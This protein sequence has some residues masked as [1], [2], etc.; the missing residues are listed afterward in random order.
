MPS[1]AK[2]Y[3]RQLGIIKKCSL[4]GRSNLRV[5]SRQKFSYFVVI[6]FESTCWKEEKSIVQEIIEFPA[7]LINSS[8]GKVESEFHYYVQP[9]EHPILSDFCKELTGITQAQVERGIPLRLCL[10][11]FCKWMRKMSEEKGFV[12]DNRLGKKACAFI[13]WSDWDLSV[14]LHNECK[15]KQIR[16]PIELNSWIDLRRVFKRFYGK[17]PAG[18]EGGLKYV[19]LEFQGRQHSGLEDSRNT[20][21]LAY[22]LICDGCVL[23][24][25]RDSKDICATTLTTRIIHS[26]DVSI[27]NNDDNNKNNI[28]SLREKETNNTRSTYQCINRKFTAVDKIS[29]P[30]IK[31]DNNKLFA[32]S[33]N[34]QRKMKK[35]ILLNPFQIKDNSREISKENKEESEKTEK[36]TNNHDNGNEKLITKS[37]IIIKT[38][39]FSRPQY[40]IIQEKIPIKDASK[41]QLSEC[42]WA[43]SK[44]RKINDQLKEKEQLGKASTPQR[45]NGTSNQSNEFKTPNSIVLNTSKNKSKMLKTPPMCQCGRR[46]KRK[47]V[48]TPGPNMGRNFYTCSYGR[49][50]SGSGEGC[51]FF[52]W[53]GEDKS[54]TN[55][56]S[57][58]TYSYSIREEYMSPEMK[59]AK[60]N[61]SSE[62]VDTNRKEKIIEKNQENVFKPVLVYSA[63]NQLKNPPPTPSCDGDVCTCSQADYDPIDNKCLKGVELGQSCNEDN[64]YCLD[65]NSHCLTTCQCKAG[66]ENVGEVCQIR[67]HTGSD[68]AQQFSGG[69]QPTTERNTIFLLENSVIK[70]SGTL[71]QYQYKPSS[72]GS[73]TIQIWR[74]MKVIAESNFYYKLIHE[75]E[76]VVSNQQLNSISSFTLAT[77]IRVEANDIIGYKTV[78]SANIG[79]VLSY[80]STACQSDTER[81]QLLANYQSLSPNSVLK[82][83]KRQDSSDCQIRKYPINA[84][85]RPDDPIHRGCVKS[86]TSDEDMSI[87]VQSSKLSVDQC[88]HYCWNLGYLYSELKYPNMCRC[89]PFF[90][91][92]D[93]D[94]VFAANI[95]CSSS[96]TRIGSNS[97][98]KCGASSYASV[99]QFP[100]TFINQKID[101]LFNSATEFYYGINATIKQPQGSEICKEVGGTLVGDPTFLNQ[102]GGSNIYVTG[103]M[104]IY[105]LPSANGQESIQLLM[106]E[107]G[108]VVNKDNIEFLPNRPDNVQGIENCLTF[109]GN[110]KYEDNRCDESSGRLLCIFDKYPFDNSFD[111]TQEITLS[112]DNEINTKW[113]QT[114]GVISYVEGVINKAIS[115]TNNAYIDILYNRLSCFDLP[116]QCQSGFSFMF[117][118]KLLSTKD[119]IIFGLSSDTG[120]MKTIKLLYISQQLK[121]SYP[122]VGN[123]ET[124]I[125]LI[126]S[127]DFTAWNHLAIIQSINGQTII[128]K[129]YV[130]GE[131]LQT[132]NIGLV[133]MTNFIGIRYGRSINDQNLQ[134]NSDIY[135]DELKISNRLLLDDNIYREYEKAA[136]KLNNEMTFK[137]SKELLELNNRNVEISLGIQDIGYK[138]NSI[139]SGLKAQ[140]ASV[141][142][143]LCTN[144]FTL[145]IWLRIRQPISNYNILKNEGNGFQL[146]YL[147]SSNKFQLKNK[148]G[149]FITNAEFSLP[150]D[151]WFHLAWKSHRQFGT[152]VFL[153]SKQIKNVQF[154]QD[155]SNTPSTSDTTNF[156]SL[157]IGEETS[158]RCQQGWEKYGEKCLYVSK[159]KFNYKR[160]EIFCKHK[161]SI[162]L[163][164]SSLEEHKFVKSLMI[165]KGISHI[166]FGLT[167]SGPDNNTWTYDGI[168]PNYI[169]PDR[170][171]SMDERYGKLSKSDTDL[172]DSDYKD[173]Y[174]IICEKP[175][176]IKPTNDRDEALPNWKHFN[177]FFYYISTFSSSRMEAIEKCNNYS[178]N[179]VSIL[180]EREYEYLNNQLKGKGSFFIG[181]DFNANANKYF[182]KDG[183]PVTAENIN[184]INLEGS[185]GPN[186]LLECNSGQNCSIVKSSLEQARFICKRK[187]R[188]LNRGGCN[189]GDYSFN[190]RCL[191]VIQE[192]GKY[193]DIV[194]KCNLLGG[195]AVS[196]TNQEDVPA[197]ES[198]MIALNQNGKSFYIGG[199]RT[200]S[201]GDYYWIT[202]E[203]VTSINLRD[204]GS[205]PSFCSI[206]KLSNDNTMYMES[207]CNN[208]DGLLCE[209]DAG[210]VMEMDDLRLYSS[211]L[212]DTDITNIYKEQNANLKILKIPC[213]TKLTDNTVRGQKISGSGKSYIDIAAT[214]KLIYDSSIMKDVL[215]IKDSEFIKYTID[216]NWNACLMSLSSCLGGFSIGFWVKFMGNK[217]LFQLLSIRNQLTISVETTLN[218]KYLNLVINELNINEKAFLPTVNDWFYLSIAYHLN[219]GLDVYANTHKILSSPT[220]VAS[221]GAFAPGAYLQIGGELPMRL[222]DFMFQTNF[223]NEKIIFDEVYSLKRLW[224]E[225]FNSQLAGSS[226]VLEEHN[227]IFGKSLRMSPSDQSYIITTDQY[228]NCLTN[229]DNCQNGIT[230]SFFMFWKEFT[231]TFLRFYINKGNNNFLLSIIGTGNNFKLTIPGR[232]ASINIPSSISKLKWYLYVFTIDFK[233]NTFLLYIDGIRYEMTSV[234]SDHSF[235]PTHFSQIQISPPEESL[236]IDELRIHN[237]IVG[238]WSYAIPFKS[239]YEYY[240]NGIL[241]NG[242]YYIDPDG[243]ESPSQ[244]V[245]VTCEMDNN[246]VQS[247]FAHDRNAKLFINPSVM[248]VDNEGNAKILLNYQLDTKVLREIIKSSVQ[249]YQQLTFECSGTQNPVRMMRQSI[250]ETTIDFWKSTP[251]ETSTI[252]CSTGQNFIQNTVLKAKDQLPITSV[253]IQGIESN[254]GEQIWSVGP[255]VCQG[256]DKRG[257]KFAFNKPDFSNIITEEGMQISSGQSDGLIQTYTSESINKDVLLVIGKEITIEGWISIGVL[258]KNVDTETAKVYLNGFELATTPSSISIDRSSNEKVVIGSASSIKNQIL[259]ESLI[260]YET[261]V[262]KSKYEEKFPRFQL[263]YNFFMDRVV[264]IRGQSN[265]IVPSKDNKDPYFTIITDNP[266]S[267]MAKLDNN[268][269]GIKL[270]DGA[271]T[272]YFYKECIVNLEACNRGFSLGFWFITNFRANRKITVLNFGSNFKISIIFETTTKIEVALTENDGSNIIKMAPISF[273]HWSH[274]GVVYD[275]SMNGAVRLYVNGENIVSSSTGRRKRSASSNSQQNIPS[276]VVIGSKESSTR[277]PFIIDDVIFKDDIVDFNEVYN[278]PGFQRSSSSS[279]SSTSGFIRRI[280]FNEFE[281]SSQ[282]IPLYPK[283]ASGSLPNGAVK[284]NDYISLNGENQYISTTTSWNSDCITN[285]ST[286]GNGFALAF[287]F[288]FDEITSQDQYFLTLGSSGINENGL[289]FGFLPTDDTLPFRRH[290]TI[291]YKDRYKKHSIWFDGEKDTWYNMF[292]SKSSSISSGLTVFLNDQKL[293]KNILTEN[294]QGSQTEIRSCI[295]GKHDK[296]NKNFAKI[297]IRTF[298]FWSHSADHPWDNNIWLSISLTKLTEYFAYFPMS[299]GKRC[300]DMCKNNDACLSFS[301]RGIH[302][303]LSTKTR[304]QLTALTSSQTN[305]NFVERLYHYL[306]DEKCQSKT[307]FVAKLYGSKCLQFS[308]STKSFT[309]AKSSCESLTGKPYKLFKIDDEQISWFNSNE[310]SSQSTFFTGYTLEDYDKLT[311]NNWAPKQPDYFRQNSANCVPIFGGKT[312]S[313]SMNDCNNNEKSYYICSTNLYPISYKGC[314]SESLFSNTVIASI[315]NVTVEKCAE[316]CKTLP[317]MRYALLKNGNIC[318]CLKFFD[319]TTIYNSRHCMIP[320]EG[321]IERYCGGQSSF[322]VY[323]IDYTTSIS[324]TGVDDFN[325]I[326]LPSTI[327]K[328]GQ[329]ISIEI[330]T[331]V[332]DKAGFYFSFSDGTKKPWSLVNKTEHEFTSPGVYYVDVSVKNELSYLNKTYTIIVQ[333]AIENLEIQSD[334]RIKFSQEYSIDLS[335]TKGTNVTCKITDEKEITINRFFPTHISQEK[336]VIPFS[337]VNN[338]TMNITC[339]NL[340]NAVSKE[341]SVIV[342]EEIRDLT[343]SV[344]PDKAPFGKTILIIWSIGKG[345][346]VSFVGLLDNKIVPID[347]VHGQ[348]SGSYKTSTTPIGNHTFMLQ[349][350]NLV[351]GPLNKTVKFQITNGISDMKLRVN[352][353]IIRTG[354]ETIATVFLSKG[355][356]FTTKIWYGDGTVETHQTNDEIQNFERVFKYKYKQPG[357]YLLVVQVTNGLNS[358]TENST[359]Y[360]LNTVK[361]ITVATQNVSASEEAVFFNFLSYKNNPK[362]T[363][364]TMTIDF[365]DGEKFKTIDVNNIIFPYYERYRYLREGFYRLQVNISNKLDDNTF[366]RDVQVGHQIKG[367]T[368]T[369]PKTTVATNVPLVLTAD[370]VKG[371]K[372]RYSFSFGDGE[373]YIDQKLRTAP[374]A[375]KFLSHSWKKEGSFD[376]LLNATNMFG[377]K[378]S[379]LT[380][381]VQEPILGL[382]LT[383]NGPQIPDKPVNFVLT[384]SEIGTNSCFKWE[385]GDGK[386]FLFGYPLCPDKNSNSNFLVIESSVLKISHNYTTSGLYKAT[387]T[388]WNSVSNTK[389]SS[390]VAIDKVLCNI[391]EV[392]LQNTGKIIKEANEVYRS[393]IVQ[394]SSTVQMQCNPPKKAVNTWS[395]YQVSFYFNG[396]EKL[397]RIQI[398]PQINQMSLK[399]PKRYLALGI[400]KVV[401]T[402]NPEG[403]KTISKEACGYFLIVSSPLLPNM[404]GGSRRTAPNN[405]DLSLDASK[406]YDPDVDNPAFSELSY[407]W[408]CRLEH[409]KF[410][411]DSNEKLI[412]TAT[413]AGSG[414]CFGDGPGKLTYSTAKAVVDNRLLKY[415]HIYVFKLVIYKDDRLAEYDQTVEIIGGQNQK[416]SIECKSNCMRKVDASQ[417]L[418]V[419]GKCDSCDM[420]KQHALTY[421]WSLYEQEDNTEKF[422]LVK[423][424]QDL[425][426]SGVTKRFLVLKENVLTFGKSYRLRFGNLEAYSEY[427]FSVNYPPYNGHCASN[428]PIGFALETYFIFK[429][430][431][432]LDE[433][434]RQ[435]RDPIMDAKQPVTLS[436]IFQYAVRGRDTTPILLFEYTGPKPET[437]KIQMPQ[438]EEMHD[439]LIDIFVTIRD[440]QNTAAQVQF[441]IQVLPSRRTA[442]EIQNSTA[443]EKLEADG[444]LVGVFRFYGQISELRT[445]I[446]R[447]CY[448]LSYPI[449]NI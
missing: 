230:I 13:T 114:G 197:L 198:I 190:G 209:Y 363:N 425:T 8:T 265:Y 18:L 277:M 55:L 124:T 65:I 300:Q 88:S 102:N 136:L 183:S 320:C 378:S 256:P 428:I 105:D 207:L 69:V 110:S 412:D 169:P 321:D 267:L 226:A 337:K 107:K 444:D 195:E 406:S 34:E 231:Q 328:T 330:N 153:N 86:R 234:F 340:L 129:V 71:L 416:L 260:L 3:A 331:D 262:E 25:T 294:L 414:G 137:V 108:N 415:G 290:F 410:A 94:S 339:S 54:A 67:L 349:A 147:V 310:D 274:I 417:S 361:F 161:E 441:K 435:K 436:Y 75:N 236:L 155:Q 27:D 355:S 268:I 115:I 266:M 362:P 352:S 11:L 225:N 96:C 324:V 142:N 395:L 80:I 449:K 100:S 423:E 384:I 58:S 387:V 381:I 241:T 264:E 237:N 448:M 196:L 216:S 189:F 151:S 338:Y 201:G 101:S 307:G 248:Q 141:C 204:E 19:G 293:T 344:K 243:I 68:L 92:K 140:I 374:F 442:K 278:S 145:S 72:E 187:E 163:R 396:T 2:D 222:R 424:F 81:G 128:W 261:F 202:G 165:L 7:V 220:P 287:E 377:Q 440:K 297:S 213:S 87:L 82:F 214:S 179:L 106:N 247:Q 150:F 439:N 393:E 312:A 28:I 336:I 4:K 353:Q 354:Y 121:L 74:L 359:I 175:L 401:V 38:R 303:Y 73:F 208:E 36:M 221:A 232:M 130:N 447:D 118:M 56:K 407:N 347:Y 323:Q 325:A 40:E 158:S 111:T 357:V 433:G 280:L 391:P 255:L 215:D 382:Q 132:V 240:E 405:R 99:Y 242:D 32:I 366:T 228:A 394:I 308:Q 203:I 298:T 358:F 246:R 380:I 60:M 126:S 244:P 186:I 299:G 227:L 12:F 316:E 26:P 285:P 152:Y 397:T 144:G 283:P 21:K 413:Q 157:V 275:K 419:I 398:P 319:I 176:S 39:K 95:R 29:S 259:I 212:P 164:I 392:D 184:Y 270:T 133:E 272:A 217:P 296:E 431:K 223:W 400:Y 148:I 364:A 329:I 154:V 170:N 367:L 79:N 317:E 9:Q 62:T 314:F 78:E 286:C 301:I 379:K 174:H 41:N 426:N 322:D 245:L 229:F 402:V 302:C 375:E 6:D 30:T 385:F 113:A 116:A 333:D 390:E 409:E 311:Y 306:P 112:F 64:L 346:L 372:C 24:L 1:T 23:T 279:T 292:I 91:T 43:L 368:L 178:S 257:I 351:S 445:K 10:D 348:L 35:K 341:I 365:G 93:D 205:S 171:P 182:W 289:V 304:T 399:L 125:S 90:G 373:S 238:D 313:W 386:E 281:E 269:N 22:K 376:I 284:T 191:S 271:L 383:N 210:T 193:Y 403:L 134:Y 33:E 123:L 371:T 438:G 51:S 194:K 53:E 200:V 249:C 166:W 335:F 173:S 127:T 97:N 50:S 343:L 63:K 84:K 291:I 5:C 122:T 46:S 48:Q 16:K 149:N 411:R 168:K 143:S 180:F 273:S 356:L 305:S 20:A 252:Q 70:A 327:L 235:D 282:T 326:I 160:A 369:A 276:E 318:K 422:N 98:W 146:K 218:I 233:T 45:T 135:L 443:L 427:D 251:K 211:A 430:E 61:L 342:Q 295:I 76:L 315:S 288:K 332:T 139:Q 49:R 258:W 370:M 59:R 103:I 446:R 66:F 388:G 206:A 85:I 44:T 239:C 309:E 89:G 360:V 57:D 418:K 104:K 83:T 250:E 263:N 77:P 17:T 408:Y 162:L 188:V 172:H 117:F 253:V 42:K 159:T 120:N 224:N 254:S 434:P 404:E 167:V 31:K 192:A 420:A 199:H 37:R 138:F 334:D 437:R 15:R 421:S 109:R 131:L 119:Q 389:A 156:N 47:C 350:S 432:W 219:H 181:M 52:S 345:T 177:G 14:C 429:C 185:N